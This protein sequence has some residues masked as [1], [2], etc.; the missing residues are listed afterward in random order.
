MVLL[1]IVALATVF[2][3]SPRAEAQYT[4]P[5]YKVEETFI[6]T[7]GELEAC[8]TQYCAKQAA[9]ELTTGQSK[10]D[11]YT[12]QT[13]FNTTSAELLEVSVQ[14]GV[15]DLG[16]LSDS[17][18]AAVSTPFTIRSYLSKGYIVRIVGTP[19]KVNTTNGP[20]YITPL[21]IQAESEVGEEQFGIN[22]AAN[23]NPGIGADPVKKPDATFSYGYAEPGYDTADWFKYND[24]DIIARSDT[25]SGE[26]EYTMSIIANIKRNT[27][28]GQYTTDLQVSVIP[29]F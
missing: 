12:A 10:S 1:S 23:T 26:M 4:S 21:S 16:I 24:G 20:V 7:G 15:F 19:P 18:T 22:L 2:S 25:S 5:S 8:G 3:W 27:L 17:T 13:G 6:G 29:T 11:A 9:G 14:G 28:A